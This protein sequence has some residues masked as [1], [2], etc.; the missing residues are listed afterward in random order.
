MSTTVGLIILAE[1]L[2]ALFIIW[3]FMHEDRFI[4]FENRLIES[5]RLRPMSKKKAASRLRVVVDNTKKAD[6]DYTAARMPQTENPAGEHL[7]DSFF[8]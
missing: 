8:L 5:F 3:G 6:P 7:R 2:V 1:A 4:R